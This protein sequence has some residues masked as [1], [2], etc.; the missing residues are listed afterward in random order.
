MLLS[1][2]GPIKIGEHTYEPPP[3]PKDEREILFINKP[4]QEQ[5]WNRSE[6]V[7]TL[8][9]YFFKWHDGVELD[10]EYTDYE[11][12]TLSKLSRKDTVELIALRDREVK[13]MKEGVWFMNNGTP[14]YLTGNHYGALMWCAMKGAKNSAEKKSTYG[15][16]MR[17]QRNYCYFIE[18]IKSTPYARGGDVVK[19]KKCGITQLQALIILIDAMLTRTSIH[20]IM[21][22]KEEV[23]KDSCFSYIA[24]ALEKMPRILCP[25]IGKQNMGEVYFGEP[26]PSRARFRKNKKTDIEYLNSWITTVPTAKN[27]FDSLTNN[28]AWIDEQSKIKEAYPEETHEI[29]IA[30]VMQGL[31]R[32]GYIIYTH[33]VSEANDR[34]FREA[35]KIY[36]D[37]KLKTINE[38]NGQTKSKLLCYAI[39]VQDGIFGA[40]DKYGDPM[41]DEIWKE[42]NA[43]HSA[44]K[45]DPDKLQAY[46]RQMPV[47]EDDCWQ[48]GAG[49]GSIFDNVRLAMQRK[50]LEVQES[51]G[52]YPYMDFNFKWSTPPVIDEI[53]GIYKFDGVP[54]IV[55]VTDEEKIDGKAHGLFKWYHPEWTPDHLLKKY[56]YKTTRDKKGKLAPN[57]GSPFY[58]AADPT[59]YALAKDVV[60]ASKNALQVFIM[61]VGEIDATVGK[62]VT[63]RRL[64]VEYLHRPQKPSEFL[65]QVIQ[66]LFTF[67]CHVLIESNMSWLAT[68]LKEWG[69]ENFLIMVNE[70]GVLVPYKEYEK[71]KLFTSQTETIGQYVAA[72][73]QH[74]APP[75]TDLDIDN[76]EFIDS[77][78]VIT[79]LMQFDP[80]NT[81]SYDAGVCYL[82]GQLGMDHYLGWHRKEQEKNSHRGDGTISR[83]MMALLG[84]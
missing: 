3:L 8:P 81:R 79:Q 20:R 9:V 61:P 47:T 36:Y 27:S 32:H 17:L 16:Y 62:R 28:T 53:K 75:Q 69:F 74:L 56:L 72:G 73:V 57:L 15:Q 11:G 65:M 7:A 6:L 51:Y 49:S 76:I 82:L 42:V 70:D 33:Y 2:P 18:I 67:G 14:T 83:A 22:T 43:Q 54:Q 12:D 46:K 35:R 34:S 39:T 60:T 55:K 21:S 41:I 77:T 10:A 58:M 63:N 23:A 30:T 68:R 80:K 78:E 37:S 40:C 59:N 19:T 45:N 26:D 1:H 50:Q 13:R 29:T 84:A 64:V 48:E 44:M 25:S 4:K 71:Q 38:G 5:F 24:Y 31:D 66:C 52:D